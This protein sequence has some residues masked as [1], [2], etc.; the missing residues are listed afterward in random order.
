MQ[1]GEANPRATK[2][3]VRVLYWL[4]AATFLAFGA[5]LMT[6]WQWTARYL[7]GMGVAVVGFVLW[8]VARIELGKSFSASAQA[9]AL[10]TTGL[11]S[12]F[13]HPIYLFGGLA[14]AGLCLAWGI[15]PALV[16]AA[17]IFPVQFLRAEREEAVLEQA[18][19]EE[20]RHYRAKTWM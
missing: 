6:K 19:G 18:F 20:F 11:Y 8:M 1:D 12:R 13:R 2:W 17:I 7:V 4:D 16:Y 10:V 9:R 5:Y 15:A 3:P 14:Y